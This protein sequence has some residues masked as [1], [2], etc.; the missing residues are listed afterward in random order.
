ME[1]FSALRAICA[2]NS[3][4]PGEFPAQRPVTRIFDVFFDLRPN[5]RLKK[6]SWGWWFETPSRSLWSHCNDRDISWHKRD[7]LQVVCALRRTQLVTKMQGLTSSILPLG[8]MDQVFKRFRSQ[9]YHVNFGE[10]PKSRNID[11][12]F[13]GPWRDL[14]AR[15]GVSAAPTIMLL[16]RLQWTVSRRIAQPVGENRP[17]PATMQVTINCSI[18]LF[19]DLFLSVTVV[20]FKQI[21]SITPYSAH[22]L[23]RVGQLICPEECV[24]AFF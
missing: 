4:V 13:H 6:Q 2:G 22:F 7:I 17:R 5:K 14:S 16:V 19:I 11:R 21:S 9:S 23:L 18:F 24:S 1:T 3:P 20:S 8:S 12:L 10:P 15:I